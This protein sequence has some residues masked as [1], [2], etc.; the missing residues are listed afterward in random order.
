MLIEGHFLIELL[1]YYLEGVEEQ[2][3]H[4]FQTTPGEVNSLHLFEHDAPQF[5]SDSLEKQPD[6]PVILH[7]SPLLS[8]NFQFPLQ[9]PLDHFN[10]P[11]DLEFIP[12]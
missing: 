11:V 6:N 5:V 3:R 10:V 8:R 2:V 9:Q 7:Q 1:L 4:D 12:S